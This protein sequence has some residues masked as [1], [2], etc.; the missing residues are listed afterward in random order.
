[1]TALI[2]GVVLLYGDTEA[3]RTAPLDG[4]PRKDRMDS[5]AL[6]SLV[7]NLLTGIALRGGAED[8]DL[9]VAGKPVSAGRFLIEFGGESPA[10]ILSAY[11]RI[12]LDDL[13]IGDLPPE[14]AGLIPRVADLCISVSNLDLKGLTALAK[15]AL[16]PA[17]D[18]RAMNDRLA[19]LLAQGKPVLGVDQVLIDLGFA[20]LKGAGQAIYVGFGKNGVTAPVLA[21][22]QVTVTGL[23]A[24][25]ER[26]GTLPNTDQVLP[27]LAL[28]KGLGKADGDRMVWNLRFDENY[29]LLVNGVDISKMGGNPR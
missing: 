6:F 16:D 25:M 7:K 3:G 2:P 5:E 15:D 24:L 18:P 19:A 1:M 8:I 21:E 10:D 11:M 27:V 20:T 13:K 28:I 9:D 17:A 29:Q 26:A 14:F 4:T 12:A 23:D 22:G